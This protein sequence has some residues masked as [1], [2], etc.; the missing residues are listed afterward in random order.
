MYL[1]AAFAVDERLSIVRMLRSAGFG[2]LVSCDTSAADEPK[3]DSTALP[4]IIDDDLTVVRAHFAR[5]NDHWRSADG[6]GALMIIPGNDAYISP[7]WYPSKAEHHRVVPTWNY[8]LVHIH[9]TI[10]IHDDTEWK[11]QLVSDLTDHNE[12]LVQGSVVDAEDS[13]PRWQVAD[14]PA[15]FIDKQLRAIVGVELEVTGI[16][17]KQKLSQNKPGADRRGA[18]AGLRSTARRRDVDTAEV[19]T[20][21]LGDPPGTTTG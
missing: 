4:F 2:H 20:E 1:P 17:A 10:R 16:Q 13:P 5:A 18:T 8:E 3:L 14:A 9:G 11:L 12:S 21:L 15:G 6:A 7:N 19:M